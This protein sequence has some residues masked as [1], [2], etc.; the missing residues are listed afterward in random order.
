[1]SPNKSLARVNRLFFSLLILTAAGKMLA[2]DCNSNGSCCPSCSRSFLR[3]RPTSQDMSLQYALDRYF[4]DYEKDADI[5]VRKEERQKAH[6]KKISDKKNS[7][8]HWRDA[9]AV[10]RSNVT[11]EPRFFTVQSTLFYNHS[12]KPEKLARYFLKG[13][14]N[15]LVVA[16]TPMGTAATPVPTDPVSADINSWW[17]E[18]SSSDPSQIF[19]SNIT[20]APQRRVIGF[21]WNLRFDLNAYLRHTWL[22]VFAPLVHVRQTTNLIERNVKGRGNYALGLNNATQGLD[23]PEWCYGRILSCKTRTSTGLDDVKITFGWD[24]V[25]RECVVANWYANLFVPTYPGSK[26]H[27][28]FEST[29]GSGGHVGLGMGMDVD[30]NVYDNGEFVLN[31]LFDARYAYFL[32]HHERRSID[33]CANGEWSR[34]MLVAKEGQ[35]LSTSYP[36]INYFTRDVKVSPRS[37]AEFLTLIHLE[38]KRF[39]IE[40]GY[41]FWWRQAE[42]LKLTCNIENEVGIFDISQRVLFAP[43]PL[44]TSSQATIIQAASAPLD[45]TPT[46][47][48]NSDFNLESARMP[49]SITS[50]LFVAMGYD[51]EWRKRPILLGGGFSYE[52][53]HTKAAYQQWGIFF[54][55]SLSF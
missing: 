12:Q 36:A 31:L 18:V 37:N 7:Q 49:K 9:A 51:I 13:G 26:S 55:N 3:H 39:N 28:L 19:S 48:T 1:M 14:K 20:L 52:F 45:P 22:E 6:Q 16:Q 38:H 41:N 43:A 40:L 54:K 30:F 2:D 5:E 17:L 29:I 44:T 23:N 50:K 47:V 21:A 32:P 25:K 15:C 34:Y 46:Y 24:F 10:H 27:Y 11:V 4:L 8:P 53:A 42:S 33:L 35:P